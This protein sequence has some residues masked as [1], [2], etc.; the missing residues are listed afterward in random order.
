MRCERELFRWWTTIM[1]PASS[2]LRSSLIGVIASQSAI[3]CITAL[4]A[5]L[6]LGLLDP[7]DGE[8]YPIDLQTDQPPLLTLGS[9]ITGQGPE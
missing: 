9:R 2:L 1:V 3:S 5:R 6:N 7:P 4:C 8:F